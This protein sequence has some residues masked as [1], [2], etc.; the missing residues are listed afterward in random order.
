MALTNRDPR[1]RPE[2]PRPVDLPQDR[3]RL[4]QLRQS[5]LLKIGDNPFLA[6]VQRLLLATALVLL[7]TLITYFG[8]DG[9][10]DSQ[11]DLPLTF[12]DAL[13]YATVSITTTGYGDIVPATQEARLIT[14]LVVTPIRVIFL[15]LLVGTTLQV[16]ADK[17]RFT[18]RRRN[19]QKG[20][21][22]HTVIC[23]FGI[24]GRSALRY[25]KS[26]DP[27]CSAVAIDE[28]EDALAAANA[29][30]VGGVLGSSLDSDILRAAGIE[31]ATRVIIALDSDEDTVVTVI[32][33]KKLNPEVKVVASCREQK[34][35]VLMTASGA[36]EVVVSSSSAGRILGMAAQSPDA[37]RVVNDLLTFGDG[38]DINE[39]TVSRAGESLEDG[40]DQTVI[41][42]VR[43]RHV[44]PSSK[45]GGEGATPE[46]LVLR[47]GA[48]GCEPLQPGDRIVFIDSRN[49]P[50][51]RRSADQSESSIDSIT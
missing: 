14:T 20:L 51:R 33:A 26:N 49:G 16:L 44:D 23:G 45:D 30:G 32:R 24:K 48:P 42:V 37:A 31:S 5:R 4:N 2:P 27:D 6:I 3:Y 19:W 7:V 15:V 36:D 39:R 28:A 9:Y 35:E 1:H 41:A 25:L 34:N 22:D 50:N 8:R 40:P 21:V 17:S 38:L 12:I 29:E 47:P 11:G 18:I 13:Y 43:P 10:T 46:Q